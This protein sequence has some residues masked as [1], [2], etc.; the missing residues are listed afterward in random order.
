MSDM[1]PYVNMQNM[2]R[3]DFFSLMI[4]EKL[5]NWGQPHLCGFFSPQASRLHLSALYNSLN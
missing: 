1:L 2:A 4:W 5:Q 3:E